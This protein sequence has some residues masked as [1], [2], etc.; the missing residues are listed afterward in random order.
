ML[1][2]SRRQRGRGIGGRGASGRG[3]EGRGT[4]GKRARGTRGAEE[5]RARGQSHLLLE[6][7]GPG[8]HSHARPTLLLAL[9]SSTAQ[10]LQ[11]AMQELTEET[12]APA[13]APGKETW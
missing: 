10:S 3:T 7:A 9:Q 5:Q 6:D 11:R 12:Q 4:D 2:P 1:Q 8:R 13:R